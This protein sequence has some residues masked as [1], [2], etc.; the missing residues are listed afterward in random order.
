MD[1]LRGLIRRT[2]QGGLARGEVRAGTD[3]EMVATVPVSTLEGA[4][5]LS[6]VYDD[7]AHVR[8]AAAHVRE[9]LDGSVAA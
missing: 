8:R 5:A 2:V 9:W 7:G 3:P 1:G 6:R 4:V